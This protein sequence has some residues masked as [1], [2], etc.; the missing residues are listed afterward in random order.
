MRPAR[1]AA[2]LAL[3][4]LMLLVAPSAAFAADPVTVAGTVVRDGAPVTGVEVVATVAGSDQ[5]VAATT[6]ETGAFGVELD[7]DVGAEVRIEVTGQTSR[8]DPDAQGC[9]RLE[10]PAG[11]LTFVVE[12]LP[13]AAVEVP[14]DDEL[15]GVVCS[16]T[17]TPGV[18]PPSTDGSDSGEVRSSG[19]GLLLVLGFL[20]ILAGG[21]IAMARRWR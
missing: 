3:A 12:A 7:L 20:A 16:P 13:P 5:I 4:L 8:S 19:A 1:S 9:V 6:D 10:T 2:L 11:E 15:T 14:L 21:T 17:A 18:T